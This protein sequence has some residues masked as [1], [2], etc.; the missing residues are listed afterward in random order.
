[1]NGSEE[2]IVIRLCL[3]LACLALTACTVSHEPITATGVTEPDDALLGRWRSTV[4]E[5]DLSPDVLTISRL[6]DGHLLVESISGVSGKDSRPEQIELITAS[7]GDERYCSVTS[8]D[9]AMDPP[10]WM[11]CRYEL[12]SPDRVQIYVASLDL[13]S[14]AVDRKL[15]SGRLHADNRHFD[16][17]EVD[18]SAEELR[19]FVTAQ[20]ARV[21]NL[22]GPLLERLP[23]Q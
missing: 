14:E 6:P 19:A 3:L 16:T 18:S 15:L 11:L 10:K 23:A 4:S 5:D 7:I 12:E 9:E 2:G 22:K 8:R 21:F 17:F 13:L 1:V 20:G